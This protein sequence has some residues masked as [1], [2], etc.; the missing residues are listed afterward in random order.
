MA[1][2]PRTGT[3]RSKTESAFEPDIS[4]LEV[5]EGTALPL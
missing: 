5:D 1:L 3:G 2:R 4:E